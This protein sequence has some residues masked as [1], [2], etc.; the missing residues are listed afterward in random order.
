MG[1]GQKTPEDRQAKKKADEYKKRWEEQEQKKSN[2][3]EKPKP[4]GI[5]RDFIE[6]HKMEI[7]RAA[8]TGATV[9]VICG[10]TYTLATLLEMALTLGILLI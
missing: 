3:E 2:S 9:V 8:D 4:K 7:K 5:C 6:K 10:T 1:K